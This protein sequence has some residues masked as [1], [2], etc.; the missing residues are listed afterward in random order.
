MHKHFGR[1]YFLALDLLM[2]I[3]LLAAPVIVQE[4]VKKQ[5]VGPLA[6]KPEFKSG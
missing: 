1:I 3:L 6:T 2:L 4:K 5:E